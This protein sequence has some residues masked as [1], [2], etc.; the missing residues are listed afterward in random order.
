MRK[1]IFAFLLLVIAPLLVISV[2]YL[3]NP[4]I[5]WKFSRVTAECVTP[6]PEC[7]A[8]DG[9]IKAEC[10]PPNI[11]EYCGPKN[12]SLVKRVLEISGLIKYCPEDGKTAPYNDLRRCPET[13]PED[14]GIKTDYGPF[15][16]KEFRDKNK[17]YVPSEILVGFKP[18]VSFDQVNNLIEVMNSGCKTTQYTDLF[19]PHAFFKDAQAKQRIEN[20]QV[21]TVS[22]AEN[23]EPEFIEK[24]LKSDLVEFAELNNCN[25]IEF[26]I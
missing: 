1:T 16:C 8:G 18:G 26:D 25:N 11:G 19:C 9:N 15:I 4:T 24:F 22:V 21:V 12:L 20:D 7:I 17:N 14:S 2:I 23:F 3:K 6:P 13:L 10:S 5:R